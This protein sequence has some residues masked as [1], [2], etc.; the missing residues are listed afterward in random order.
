MLQFITHPSS[1]YSIL[2]E[3]DMA[4]TGGCRW[5]Q[6]RLKDAADDELRAVAVDVIERCRQADAIVVVDDHVELVEPLGFDG[7]HLGNNDRPPAEAR[8]MLGAGP[9]IGVTAH[10]ADDI[11]RYRGLDID[12]FGIGPFK[13]TST[14]ARPAE[15]LGLDGYRDIVATI[16]DAGVDTPVVAI[17]GITEADIDP[18][19]ATGVNGI[20]LSGTIINATSPVETT[21]AIISTLNKYRKNNL[22]T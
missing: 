9:F 20:A 3:V 17:G 10:T 14:K 21:R 1:R 2:E 5:I 19:M 11:L 15:P 8:E 6:L 7:V 4:L 12:Y 22:D 16:R 13:P 18:L